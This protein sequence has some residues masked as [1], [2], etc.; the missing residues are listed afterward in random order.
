[1]TTQQ[2]A[3]PAGLTKPYPRLEYKLRTFIWIG[4]FE[5]KDLPKAAGFRWSPENKYWWTRDK[6]RAARLK[7]FAD[8]SCAAFWPVSLAPVT[9]EINALAPPRPRADGPRVRP[10]LVNESRAIDSDL[11]IPCPDGLAY[12]NYQRGGIAYGFFRFKHLD[13]AKATGGLLIADEPRLGKTI[14]ALGIMNLDESLRRVL[15]VCPATARVNWRRECEKWLVRRRLVNYDRLHKFARQLE[16][17]EFDAAIIDES[18]KIK[19]EQARQSKHAYAIRARRL[20][21]MTGTPIVN[22]P[23]DLW[24]LVSRLAPDVFNDFQRYKRLYGKAN[25]RTLPG[26]RALESLQFQLR[27][28]CMVRRTRKEVR[29][30]LPDKQRE[31]IVL[32]PAGAVGALEQEREASQ[33]FTS[34]MFALRLRVELAKADADPQRYKDAVRD[35]QDLNQHQF[36]EMSKV[37]RETAVAKVPMIIEHL[38]SELE[39]GEKIV[40][41]AHHRDV[42]QPVFEAFKSVAVRLDGSMTGDAG[43][44][45]RQAS[46]DAFQRDPKVLLFVGSM[47]AASEAITLDAGSHVVFG[48]LDWTTKTMAQAEARCDSP[49]WR[50]STAWTPPSLRSWLRPLISPRSR[51]RW[52]CAS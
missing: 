5:H 13:E 40:F 22:K 37:R 20:I 35:L 45:E 33:D 16:A 11:L 50:T 8:D 39:N 23:M 1:M 24:P 14:Q 38:R 27:Q 21:Y 30:D 3:R 17:T 29:P 49:V 42:I 44:R 25:V 48:E 47:G 32:P 26:R 15:I 9:D 19:N 51:Q 43:M 18:H 12:R 6:A 34:R 41:F 10:S 52:A 4:G 36:S 46:I 28:T 2:L 7:S 31:V